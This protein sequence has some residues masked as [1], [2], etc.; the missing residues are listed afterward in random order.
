MKKTL[1]FSICTFVFI[2]TGFSQEKA[3][4]SSKVTTKTESLMASNGNLTQKQ[5]KKLRKKHAYYLAHNKLNKTL[6]MSEDERM[7]HGLPPNKYLEQEWLNTMNPA[8]GRPTPENLGVIRA[9]LEQDRAESRIVGDA[10]ANPWQERGPN[11]VGG[12][13]KAIMFDPTDTAGNTVIAGGISGGLW[14]NTNISSSTTA[15]TR[16]TTLPEH[17][18]VQNITADPNNSSI[19]YVGT[20]ETYT[21]DANGNGIWKTTDAGASWTRVF[22]GGTP[23]SS[24]TSTIYNLNIFAP[25]NAGVIRGYSTSLASFGPPPFDL[26]GNKLIVLVNDG[27]TTP[28][29]TATSGTVDDACQA[30]TAGSLTGKIA[31]IRRGG[32]CTFESKALVAQNAGAIG[33]IIMNN[34]T[35][36]VIGMADSGLG[37]LIPTVMISKEDG[38]LLV[39]NLTNLTGNFAPTIPGQFSGTA[40][41]GIQFINDIAIKN[42]GSGLSEIYAAVGDAY[43]AGY[44]NS[45]TYGLYK[46]TNGGTTWTGPLSLPVTASGNKTCPF[47]LEIAGTGTIW[48]STTDSTTFND[49]GG[50]IFASTNNGLTWTLKYTVTGGTRTEIE[51]ST[52]TTTNDVIYV[53]AQITPVSPATKETVMYKTTNGFSTAPTL[54]TPPASNDSRDTTYGFTG[55]QAFYDM[56]IE[57][58]PTNDA[59][60]Y[61]G[62]LNVHKSTNSGGNWTQ[63][64][65]GYN[66]NNVHGDLHAMTFKPGTPD[67][68]LFGNDGGVYYCASLTA[69]TSTSAAITSR[70]VGFNVTQF[71]GVAVSPL[72][73]GTNTGDFF[74]AG[75]QDN[76][77]N[78]FPSSK[79]TS[80]GVTTGTV[81]GSNEVQG[82]DGGI[83]L[84]K[85]DATT[86]ASSYYVTNYVYNDNMNV[87]G[88]NGLVKKELNFSSESFGQFYPAMS[89][90][91]S[92]N[93]LY[94]DATDG[95]NRTYQVRRYTGLAGTGSITAFIGKTLLVNALLTAYPTALSVGKVPSTT[96]YIGTSNS[97]LLKLVNANTVAAAGTGWSDISVGSGFVGTISD[98]EFGVNDS[99]IFV[100]L[101]NYGTTNIWYTPNGGT[102]WYSIEGDLPDMPVH[103]ILQNP[104]NRAEVMVGTELGVWYADT[105]NPATSA[106]QVL[107]WKQAYNGMSGVKVTDLDLQPNL[108]TAPTAYNVFAA[109]YGR[110]VFSGPLTAAPLATEDFSNSKG[111]SIYPNPSNG[112][113]N[114]NIN[115]YSGKVNIQVA[116]LNGREVYAS[117]NEMFNSEKAVDLKMLESGIYVLRISGEDLNYSQKIIKN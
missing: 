106:T 50:Q 117:K 74:V 54:I 38:D 56:F 76:G 90:D 17:L 49:G 75:A 25:S 37:A 20:G 9:Q 8:L 95:T 41:S 2:T 14:K 116:D 52:S 4:K 6:A 96:L 63:I 79:S 114:I 58:D 85:Q 112:Q 73:V 11:N 98:I 24:T 35:G 48:L 32:G 72:G 110:G 101:K 111:V 3:E 105:F 87:R 82:G 107:N 55:G 84:F 31:L 47:D 19:W 23:V 94:S 33:V 39:A 109:T 78:Y 100:T 46:S 77:S 21:G 36:G 7:A 89:L 30:L 12:R 104:L 61:V 1:L 91:S 88:L 57:V 5:V 22:G 108:P 99:Q 44:I 92:N 83:P 97:K 60:I 115:Q 66:A 69:A 40:V 28:T 59:K 45:S 26:G 93:I 62:G 13:T 68:A 43:N 51:A 70:N 65:D 10:A 53:L 71:V 15:W 80:T 64:T 81:S 42:M 16:I 103:T 102:N 29:A 113:F 18:N 34:V 86:S 27:S 67:T